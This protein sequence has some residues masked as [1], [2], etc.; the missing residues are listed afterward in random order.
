M[1]PTTDFA[2]GSFFQLVSIVTSLRLSPGSDG[3]AV[4]DAVLAALY[5]YMD[6]IDGWTDEH[7][8]PFGRGVSATEILPVL[9][10][11]NGVAQVNQ[12]VLRPVDYRSLEPG[13]PTV[14]IVPPEQGL[15]IS[16]EHQV[17]FR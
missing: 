17:E 13:D 16:H 9:T 11:V 2:R 5:D 10:S 8:W 1:H 12:I 4:R 14:R 3:E 15:F 7:G 6:P